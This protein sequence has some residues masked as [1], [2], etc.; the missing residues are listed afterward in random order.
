MALDYAKTAAS[1]VEKVGGPENVD[2]VSHCMTRLRFILKDDAK[3]DMEAIK[4]I[5]GVLGCVNAGGQMQVI[6]GQ[7]LIDTYNQVISQFSFKEGAAIDENLDEDLEPLTWKERL[8][9]AHI[10]KVFIDYVS[11]SVTPMIPGLIAG[12]ML[13]VV[14]LLIT[15][16]IP[17]FADSSTYAMLSIVGDAPF[18]FMPIMVA[19]GASKKLNANPIYAM[20]VAAAMI[21]PTFIERVNAATATDIFG[22]PVHLQAYT[23]QMFPSLMIAWVAAKLETVFNKVVPGILRAVLVGCLTMGV[24]YTVTMVALAPIGAFVGEA[25]IGAFTTLYG[26]GGPI[27][28]GLLTGVLPFL[29]MTGM[30]TPFGAFMTQ[31]LATNGYDPLLRPAMFLHNMAEGGAVLG[32]FLRAKDPEVKSE[33]LTV[34]VGCIVAGVT[35][36]A[37][38]G[39]NLRLKKPLIATCAGG[40]IGGVV[41]GILGMRSFEFGYSNIW[42]L[43]IFGETIVAAII[44]TVTAIA[45]AAI[46]TMILGFDEKVLTGE[47]A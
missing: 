46:I 43:P 31:M 38:Y 41:A 10:G 9:P 11:A 7:N 4:G 21:S 44:A 32:I 2:S 3:A 36:P 37:I 33:A 20:L 8:H 13:K 6:M 15:K 26:I 47:E 34:A 42:A 23:S 12:G 45:S 22:L 27:V 30:H 28:I 39:F 40:F 16:V 19:Y 25:L 18:Y 24:T 35:E 14:L 17:E 5:K 1:I 29:V